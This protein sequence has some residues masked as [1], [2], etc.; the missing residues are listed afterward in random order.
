M[1]ENNTSDLGVGIKKKK[2]RIGLIVGIVSMVIA[3]SIIV[4]GIIKYYSNNY[5]SNSD[6]DNLSGLLE[7]NNFACSDPAVCENLVN[8]IVD[9]K[10][11]AVSF[12]DRVINALL[13]DRDGNIYL[14]F[15]DD[16]VKLDGKTD[17]KNIEYIFGGSFK[18][19][20]IV[21]YG[22]DSFY[23]VNINNYK[24]EEYNLPADIKYIID[25]DE[26]GNVRAINKDGKGVIYYSCSNNTSVSCENNKGW[27]S[28]E[29]SFVNNVSYAGGRIIL[30]EDRLYSNNVIKNSNFDDSL[31]MDNVDNIWAWD[32]LKTNVYLMT[33]NR[34]LELYMIEATSLSEYMKFRVYFDDKVENVYFINAGFYGRAVVVGENTVSLVVSSYN[35]KFEKYVEVK[36]IEGLNSYIKDIKGFYSEDNKLFVLLSDGNTYLLKNFL[37]DN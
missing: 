4:I 33:L 37:E 14:K 21:I 22:D 24:I 13:L 10:D 20:D 31:V 1:N 36:K 32:N 17:L 29:V 26:V 18:L 25:F 19:G 9:I 15:S 8:N 11:V 6:Y 23:Y 5:N 7:R 30:I 28:E 35:D 2:V 16:I 27:Y 12:G 3:F 34:D